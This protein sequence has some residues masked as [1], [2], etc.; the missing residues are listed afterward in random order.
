MK[1]TLLLP[2]EWKKTHSWGGFLYGGLIRKVNTYFD[3][4]KLKRKEPVVLGKTL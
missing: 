1:W 4:R 3:N 2:Q